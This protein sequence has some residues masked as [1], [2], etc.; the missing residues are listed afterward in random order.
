MIIIYKDSE[1]MVVKPRF[2]S[3]FLEQGWS[4]EPP[5]S[6]KVSRGRVIKAEADIIPVIAPEVIGAAD[7]ITEVFAYNNQGDENGNI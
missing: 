5:A 4:Q 1:Q 6:K 7:S 3:R 2:L